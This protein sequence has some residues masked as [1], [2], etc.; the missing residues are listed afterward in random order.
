MSSGILDFARVAGKLKKTKRTGWVSAVGVKSPE[1]VADHTFRTAILAMCLGDLKKLVKMALLHDVHEA[2]IGDLD[3]SDKAELGENE[4]RIREKQAIEQVFSAL[5]S[6]LRQEYAALST[7][8]LE[9]E[10]E[11]AKLVRQIDQLEMVIQAEEYER[12][13]YDRCKLQTFWDGVENRLEDN[14]LKLLFKLLKK[15]K[16][17]QH[18]TLTD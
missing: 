18:L 7:E 5:P 14:D 6:R 15:E 17:K 11:E 9:Q 10:T 3:R 8:F 2:L 16:Q 12:E 4:L 1:S 13:G